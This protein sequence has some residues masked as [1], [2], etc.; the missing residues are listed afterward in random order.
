MR[1]NIPQA[2]RLAV[3]KRCGIACHYCGRKTTKQNRH[4]DHLLPVEAG[5]QNTEENLVVACKRCNTEKG[6]QEYWSYVNKR[7]ELTGLHLRT[8]LALLDK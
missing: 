1:K 5:G 3:V 6:K 8:L 4:L 2:M 7:I